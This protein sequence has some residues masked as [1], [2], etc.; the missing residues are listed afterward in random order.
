M[1]VFI[2][3][4]N[5]LSRTNYPS[6]MDKTSGC[7]SCVQMNF[8]AICLVYQHVFKTCLQTNQVKTNFGSKFDRTP[9]LYLDNLSVS[10]R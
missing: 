4:M 5:Y 2:L 6:E 3:G 7:K 8:G 10:D 9:I 1:A